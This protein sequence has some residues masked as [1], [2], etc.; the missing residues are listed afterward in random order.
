MGKYANMGKYPT[1]EDM[2]RSPPYDTTLYARLRGHLAAEMEK[3]FDNVI[4]DCSWWRRCA[5][6]NWRRRSAV[7]RLL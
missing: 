3:A 7:T 5:D 6:W 4:R 2:V 1:Y